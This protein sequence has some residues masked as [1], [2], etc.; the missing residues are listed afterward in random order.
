MFL[1]LG[2]KPFF[3]SIS[4][5]GGAGLPAKKKRKKGSRNPC[6]HRAAPPRR[7]GPGP[8]ALPSQSTACL[9]SQRIVEHANERGKTPTNTG[10]MPLLTRRSPNAVTR[11]G[12][13]EEEEEAYLR[14]ETRERV[15]T[16]FDSNILFCVC[17]YRQVP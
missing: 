8:A 6:P 1:L 12:E 14:L 2:N 9:R 13:K 3:V 4:L 17:E 5:W 11:L 15:Q 7:P 16:R 10:L